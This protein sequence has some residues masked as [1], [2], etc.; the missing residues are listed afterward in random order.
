MNSLSRAAIAAAA[1]S[2][3][4]AVPI[5]A[6][7]KSQQSSAANAAN[8][9]KQGRVLLVPQN[10]G[11]IQAAIDS[12]EAGDTVFVSNGVYKENIALRDS[13]ALIG[14]SSE[15]VVIAGDKR[16]PVVKGAQGATLR[17][18]TVEGGHTGVL[19]AN[20]FMAI[21]GC[22]IRGNR[23]SGIH[24]IITMPVIRNNI[25]FR[26]GGSGVFCETTRSHR[27]AIVHNLIA[28]NTYSG[29]HLA[30][31]SEVLL[32][33][34]VLYFNKQYGVFAADGT[35]RSRLSH[36]ALYGNRHACNALTMVDLTN[37]YY[38]PAFKF[39]S[40]N[41]YDFLD[42]RPEAYR[43]RGKEGR[44]IG[45]ERRSYYVPPSLRPVKQQ[46]PAEAAKPEPAKPAAPAA[47]DTSTP[48]K[49]AAAPIAVDTA[50]AAV[51][52]DVKPAGVDAAKPA[53]T[54]ATAPGGLMGR[55]A[56][57]ADTAK[58]AV[59]KPAVVDTARAK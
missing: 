27:G 48:A 17:H 52:A 36:N 2:L 35:R 5:F 56:P 57:S 58:P 14:A 50:K 55:V 54:P 37:V 40:A 45:L 26:N 24:C 41:G 18:V 22:V 51:K 34:N 21:E 11:L 46:R 25:I 31:Y 12:S 29:V 39:S 43:G 53:P 1:L 49:A 38:D 15:R 47:V 16:K 20:V 32:E 28:E 42:A 33:H 44:D 7:E 59:V 6:Q 8:A 4:A 9:A 10:Y 30:G 13:V 19:C 3:F 23:V